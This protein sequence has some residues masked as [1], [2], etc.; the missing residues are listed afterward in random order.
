MEI[1]NILTKLEDVEKKYDL[2]DIAENLKQEYAINSSKDL[3]KSIEENQKAGRELRLGVIGRVKAGKS[4]LINSLIFNGETILPK[5]ATPMTAALTTIEHSDEFSANI[6]FY[7]KEDIEILKNKY[8]EYKKVFENLYQKYLEESKNEER[9][10]KKA[11]RELK[12]SSLFAYYEQYEKIQNSNVSIDELN[13][14]IKASSLNTLNE[15]LK[16]YVGSSGKYMPFTKAVHLKIDKKEIKGIKIIDTPGVNDPVISREERTK[17]LLKDCDVIFIVSPS[18]QFL[19]GDD[20]SLIDRVSS[21]E[22]I[23]EI[24]L[25]ASQVDTQLYGSEKRDDLYESLDLISNKLTNYAIDVFEKDKYLKESV[26]YQ[27]IKK[28]KVLTTSAI[29]FSIYQKLDTK[30]FDDTE[31]HIFKMLQKFYNPYFS[32]NAKENLLKL[33]NIPTLKN[34]IEDVRNRKN[35]IVSQKMKEF[36]EVKLKAIKNYKNALIKEISNKIKQIQNSN[37]EDIK[38]RSEKLEQIK[39]K[40]SKI[41]NEEFND[42]VEEFEIDAKNQLLNEVNKFF[43]VTK[44]DIKSSEDTKTE[45]YNTTKKVEKDGV[46]ASIGRFF[47]VGGYETKTETHTNTYT[48]VRAGIVRNSIEELTDN[49]EISIDSSLKDYIVK[50][51]KNLFKHLVGVLRENI[52]DE[53]LDVY[54]ISSVL[55][56]VVNSV[57]IPDISYKDT[58]PSS[59]QKNGVLESYEAEEFLNE[60]NEYVNSLKSKVQNDIK[61]YLNNLHKKLTSF[62]IANNIFKNYD[63]EIEKLQKEV[64]DKEVT[65]KR[66][67]TILKELDF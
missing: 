55:R 18:G 26:V 67:E 56:K 28:N 63:E 66:Y 10:T 2:F 19:N 4:S 17:E 32:Q 48:I 46:F 43:Q 14:E 52:G 35:E 33:S 44:E 53:N 6:E 31:A 20:L 54:T 3:K 7:S 27:Y 51:R 1:L 34:L 5:A 13:E 64:K 11:N 21:K 39:D 59:L 36:E 37:I 30:N 41:I 38:A 49:I 12:D 40:A 25:V 65:I 42:L 50:F 61:E 45:T 15:K 9:A 47:G 23:R 29:A 62:D 16:D 8:F 22:G 57:D 60:S 58:F 24:Y